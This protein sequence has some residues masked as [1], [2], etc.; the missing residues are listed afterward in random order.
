MNLANPI[1]TL[2]GIGPRLEGRFN[3]LGVKTVEDLL[4]YYPKRY[5]DYSKIIT[6]NKIKPGRVTISGIIKQVK[7]RYVRRGLSITEAI[8][9]DSSGSV[10]IVWFNQAYLEKAI[11]LGQHYYISGDYEL[12]YHY[13]SILNPTIELVSDFPLNT[14]R[15]KPIYKETKGLTSKQIRLTIRTALN[16]IKLIDNR[17]PAWLGEEQNLMPYVQAIQAIHFPETTNQLKKA[18]YR[19]AFEEIFYLF[20]TSL[21]YKQENKKEVAVSIPFNLELALKFVKQLP[22]TLTDDQRRV[23]WQ[24]FRDI[25]KAVPMNRLVEG[26]VGS[27]KTVVAAMSGLMTIASNW[28]VAMMAPTELLARQHAETIHNM[29]SSSFG[30]QFSVGLLTGSMSEVQKK[31]VRNRLVNGQINFIIGT[32]AL[33]TDKVDMHKLALIIIDEQHRFGVDQRKA[34]QAKAGHMP[35]VLTLSATPIP[36]SLA[37]TLYGELNM[38]ILSTKPIG[39]KSIK[40]TIVS[41]NSRL[42]LYKKLEN[43]IKK[44]RQIYYVCPQI[45]KSTREERQSIKSVEEIYNTLAKSIFKNYT[46]DLLHGK[47]KA[48]DKQEI[49]SRF[50]KGEINIL[51]STT[52]IEVGVDVNNASTIVIENADVFGLAQL[53]QLRG[54]VGRSHHQGYC[55]LIS[56]DSKRP[57]KRLR[58]LESSN[59]GFKLAELD[60]KMRG[61]GAIY[62]SMQHGNLDLRLAQLDD[63]ALIKAAR[64]SASNFLKKKEDLLQYTY[65][66][67]KVQKLRA[68][69]NLN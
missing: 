36:R 30:D 7:T 49:M 41:P 28:Q 25:E 21:L 58:A 54:R 5:E 55:Y 18:K 4:E 19:L 62:G 32:H 47:M 14:A 24:I 16:N 64:T 67:E 34:L 1:C 44:G 26:D 66:A 9:S 46:V 61:P 23:C 57:S 59:D 50:I 40:T 6:I 52:V 65:L 42:S 53:H 2:P 31:Q 45:T 69:T 35:H 39:R 68:V 15:I 10:R 20:L 12:K 37:L 8:A 56:S 17:L 60:L 22:F 48:S 29:I 51:V 43:E 38:S 63:M 33:I 13:F 27:G 11:R 3:I